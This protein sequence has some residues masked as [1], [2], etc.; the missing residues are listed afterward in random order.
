MYL[1]HVHENVAICDLA[2]LLLGGTALL[3]VLEGWSMVSIEDN[4]RAQHR[5]AFA[6]AAHLAAEKVGSLFGD[7]PSVPVKLL[8][9]RFMKIN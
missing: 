3:S 1:L 7:V 8:E 5:L 6:L 4:V 9:V 2:S